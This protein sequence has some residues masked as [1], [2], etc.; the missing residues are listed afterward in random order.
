MKDRNG[1]PKPEPTWR[2]L[3][4]AVLCGSLL[5]VGVWWTGRQSGLQRG[6][7]IVRS[8]QEEKVRQPQV[9][10]VHVLEANSTLSF[11]FTASS[12]SFFFTIHI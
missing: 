1:K 3:A 11:S 4:L 12:Q 7:G 6:V 2:N 5:A 9:S 10:N 8:L